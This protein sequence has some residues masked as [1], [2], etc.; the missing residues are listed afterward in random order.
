MH[1]ERMTRPTRANP[2]APGVATP[3]A[4]PHQAAMPG[5]RIMIFFEKSVWKQESALQA[6]SRAEKRY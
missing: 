3:E 4:P 5:A 2:T 1:G 6:L